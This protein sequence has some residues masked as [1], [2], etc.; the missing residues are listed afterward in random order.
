MTQPSSTSR[1]LTWLTTLASTTG[2]VGALSGSSLWAYIFLAVWAPIIALKAP[3]CIRL[4]FRTPI[5]WVVPALAV[6]STLWSQAPAVTLRAGLELSATI[7]IATLT[8]G[9]VRPRAFTAAVLVSLML[10]AMASLAFGRSGIDGLSGE[11]VFMGVFASKNTMAMFMSL[12]TIFAVAVAA[13]A[14]QKPIMRLAAGFSFALA[15]PLLLKAHSA[16]A[17]V[18][19]ALSF[20]IMAITVLFA[21]LQPRERM[22]VLTVTTLIAIPLALALLILALNG[23][24]ARAYF[25]FIT[26]VLGKDPT[27]TGRTV[28]WGI[29]LNLIHNRPFLGLGYDAFWIQGNLLPEGIWREFQIDSRAGFSFHD[30]YLELAVGLGWAGVAALTV[31]LWLALSRAIRLALDRPSWTTAC[32]VTV[33]FCLLS[34]SIDEA[35]VPAPFSFLTYLLFV[36]VSYGADY[37]AGKRDFPWLHRPQPMRQQA[38]MVPVKEDA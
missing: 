23:T 36:I 2:L 22:L 6:A 26:R 18:T 33:I 35:D 20:T 3:T 7:A 5:L 32:F 11:T 27:L 10:G 28:L 31:T 9:L 37:V 8:A 17:L 21:R 38:V 12:L 15:V 24:L 14:N 4:I 19:T 1:R 30:T 29:A 25:D 16:G 13:D 34:R